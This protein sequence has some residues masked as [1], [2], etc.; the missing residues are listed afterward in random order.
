MLLWWSLRL[1]NP[2]IRIT[3]ISFLLDVKFVLSNDPVISQKKEIK[4]KKKQC[5]PNPS[6]RTVRLGKKPFILRVKK[7]HK[8]KLKTEHSFYF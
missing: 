1:L 8:A 5:S 6:G 4:K 7:L 3:F 2:I